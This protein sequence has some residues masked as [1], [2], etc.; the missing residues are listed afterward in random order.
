MAGCLYF[1]EH[2]CDVGAVVDEDVEI[3]YY[4]FTWL[5]DFHGGRGGCR[6]GVVSMGGE[7][8]IGVGV[9][10]CERGLGYSPGCWLSVDYLHEQP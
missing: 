7:C 5:E 6:I 8:R 1:G 3:G 10:L 4:S 2:F 9:S